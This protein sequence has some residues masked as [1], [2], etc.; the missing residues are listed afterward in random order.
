LKIIKNYDII[1]IKIKELR[2]LYMR[3][4]GNFRG[5]PVYLVTQDMD[6]LYVDHSEEK[7]YVIEGKLTYHGTKLADVLGGQLFDF[8]EDKFNE[9]R[10]KSWG[11]DESKLLAKITGVAE[12][13]PQ[14]EEE[15]VLS[16]AERAAAQNDIAGQFMLEWRDN[17]DKEIAVLKSAVA[18]MEGSLDAVG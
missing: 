10:R 15:P 5:L 14:E 9:L 8:D 13:R 6:V 11:E 12:T 17:I 7:M 2:F 3:K 1:Y 16:D 4:M 18:E